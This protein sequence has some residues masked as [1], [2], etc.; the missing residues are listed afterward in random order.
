MG[1][2][3]GV[4]LIPTPQMDMTGYNRVTDSLSEFRKLRK[5]I[6]GYVIHLDLRGVVLT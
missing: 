3:V 6:Y 5:G 4:A 2:V 1:A